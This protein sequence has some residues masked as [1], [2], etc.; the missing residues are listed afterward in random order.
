MRS[1]DTS[2]ALGSRWQIDTPGGVFHADNVI[3]CTPATTAARLLERVSPEVANTFD[4]IEYAS[5]ALVTFVLDA[6]DVTH[7]LDGSGLLVPRDEGMLTT[8]CSWSSSKWAH[9]H[10]PGSAVLRVSAGRTDDQRWL[11]M[12][13]AG[14]AQTLASE[15]AEMGLIRDVVAEAAGRALNE[16]SDT[17][18]PLSA[19]SPGSP[20]GSTVARSWTA[21][22]ADGASA[23]RVNA[24]HHS[25]P[26]YEPDHLQ[27]M[28]IVDECL[29]SQAPGLLAAGAAMRGLGIPACIRQAQTAVRSLTATTVSVGGN[30]E[31]RP[32]G[33]WGLER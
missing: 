10:R 3:L 26:Q 24:W 4:G 6:E 7:R 25:L 22:F 14:L 15:L 28:Q 2:P 30:A 18:R 31:P 27:R 5:V 13:P 20:D 33:G 1:G 21:D 9:F 8:A 29:A 11:D 32:E 12:T 16:R 17:S 19:S 23:V